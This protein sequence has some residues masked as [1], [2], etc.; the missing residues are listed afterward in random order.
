MTPLSSLQEADLDLLRGLVRDHPTFRVYLA[1][2]LREARRGAINRFARIGRAREGAA[3]AIVFDGLEARTLVGRFQPD[4]ELALADMASRAELHLEP[5]AA[6]RISARLGARLSSRR[7]LLYYRLDCRPGAERDGRCRRLGPEDLDE[8][9]AFFAAHYPETVFSTW[10]L[11][12]PFLGLYEGGTL[13]ACGGVHAMADGIANLG[14]FLTSPSARGRGL[15]RAVAASLAHVLADQ[16]VGVSTLGTTDDNVAAH[17]A[18][19][20]IGFRCFDSRV[21]LNLAAVR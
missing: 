17:R 4:E 13:V 9:A 2:G 18:Y 11:E 20:A 1:D 5:D 19:E 10:M 3:L 12:Q 14:N 15:A 7:R 6:D 21:Q 8:V 16:G